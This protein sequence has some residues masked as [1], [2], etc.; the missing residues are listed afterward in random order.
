M[1]PE[2]KSAEL[3]QEIN[4]AISEQTIEV[5]SARIDELWRR[6]P[7]PSSA[8]FIAP[9][10]ERLRGQLNLARLRMAVLRSYTVEPVIPLLRAAAFGFRVDLEVHVGDYNAYM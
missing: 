3:R 5:A 1:K 10:I 9:H 7:G 2:E 8:A 6:E 4:R